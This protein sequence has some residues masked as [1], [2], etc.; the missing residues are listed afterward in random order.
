MSGKKERERRRQE[1]LEAERAAGAADRRSRLLK[2][3]AGLAF[4]ALAALVVVIVVNAS[5][6]GGGDVDLEGVEEA[7]RELAGIPQRGMVLGDPKAPVE[8]IEFGD[9]QC[10]A[11]AAYAQ[12]ILPQVIEGPIKRGEAKLAFKNFTI[13]GP[14][15]TVAGAAAVAA[16]AQN[17]AWSFIEVF[18]RNQGGE[19]AGYV[20]DQFLEAVAKA[21]GVRDLERWR[22]EAK[23]ERATQ[24]VE[25]TTRQ[26]KQL[27]L[28]GT[29][30][31]GVRGPNSD[32]LEIFNAGSA[33]DLEAAIEAAR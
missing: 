16:G 21:A 25:A 18:Y 10:P 26:A 11:C 22:R 24:A 19:N 5:G 31:F 15:S 30:S 7:N 6:G 27:G 23:A 14:D 9:L 28:T 32:G 13:I 3:S 12:Q 20:T 17:R 33:G 4:L 29:P 1:R 2:L 8:L